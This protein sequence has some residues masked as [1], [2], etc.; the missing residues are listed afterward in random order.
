MPDNLA[1]DSPLL[2]TKLLT[3]TIYRDSPNQV[4][5]GKHRETWRELNDRAMRLADGLRNAG[6]EKGSKVAVVDF[7][8]HNYLEAYYA[9]PA[10]QAVLHTVNIRL[11]PEQIA[12]TMA[13]AEDEAVIVRD[14]FAP[15]LTKLLPHVKSIKTI[16]VASES[17]SMPAGA[18]AGSVFYDDLLSRSS[19]NFQPEDFDENSLATLF[20]TSGTTGMPKGVSFTHRQIVLHTI[21][22][23]LAL[24]SSQ[25]PVRL[26]A[27]DVILPLVPMFHVHGWGFPYASGLLGQKY[28]LV[29]KYDPGKILEM[30]SAEKATWSHMVPTILN[31]VLHHPTVESHR[32]ALSRWKVVVGGAAL[33]SEL[34]RKAMS[35][36]IKIMSGYGLSET[37][38]ILTLALPVEQEYDLPPQEMLQKALLKTGMPIP[39]VDLRIVDCAMKDVPRDG[40]TIGEIVVRAPWTTKEYYKDPALSQELWA[41]G[42]LHTKDLAT[43]DKSGHV[44]IADR[45]KDAVKSGGEWI[46]TI[47][48]EDILMRHPSVLEAA[49]IGASD[50]Q[51]GERP[52]AIIT[53]KP[54]SRVDEPDLKNHFHGYVESGHI[55]KFWVPDRYYVIEEPLPKTSTGKIDKKPLREKYSNS[56]AK[57]K[58]S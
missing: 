37:A 55:A 54:G 15:L 8:T 42:W 29:G 27:R 41:G 22:S 39:L 35:F 11:P 31:M 13:H 50:E 18:P 6:I 47:E 38:P 24:A 53:L 56:A 12:Y 2:I 30:L 5:F 4:V 52:V 23:C 40:K 26:E 58:E 16:V 7:D 43:V 57:K 19:G 1:Y 28:V 36:G 49:V 44:K 10:I 48:L 33:P 3:Q 46:S 9:V 51:W 20:Y 14:E 21:S 25:S 45:A 34:A 32:E 17:G